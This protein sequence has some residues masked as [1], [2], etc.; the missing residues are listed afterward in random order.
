M[1]VVFGNSG[2]FP[3]AF[4]PAR[5]TKSVAGWLLPRVPF[6]LASQT[7]LAHFFTNISTYCRRIHSA[8][9]KFSKGSQ[10]SKVSKKSATAVSQCRGPSRSCFR[11][12]C[13]QIMDRCLFSRN[14]ATHTFFHLLKALKLGCPILLANCFKENLVWFKLSG[15]LGSAPPKSD[16]SS[17]S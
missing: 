10:V 13:P 15:A 7:S 4:L 2:R 1:K 14:P 9:S 17:L 8:L 16:E 6:F 5:S 12:F 11:R 3:L